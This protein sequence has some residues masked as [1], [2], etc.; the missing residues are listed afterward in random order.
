LTEV[1]GILTDRDPAPIESIQQRSASF[2]PKPTRAI[3]TRNPV[4]Q[5]QLKAPA[6]DA[7]RV[8]A[9]AADAQAAI[10]Q[11]TEVMDGLEALVEQET[12][13]VR[14]GH[15]RKAAEIEPKKTELA[16]RYFK[17]VERLKLN[18]KFVARTVPGDLG[19]LGQRHNLLQARLKTNLM[20]LATA[21]AI[22]EGIVRRLSGHI[23]R[24][25]APQVYGASGRTVAPNPKY[26]R[27]LALSRTS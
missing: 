14:A 25:T 4:M 11:L 10:S 21:H 17:A 3:A 8:L 22:S 12:A 16:G 26:A 7:P 18:A 5:T 27:P 6:D 24:K 15:L 20:V 2:E 13:L 9:T 19:A 1:H 23:A